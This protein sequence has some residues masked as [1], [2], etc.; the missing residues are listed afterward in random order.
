MGKFSL[1]GCETH[2]IEKAGASAIKDHL[3]GPAYEL[4][5]CR[6]QGILHWRCDWLL[7]VRYYQH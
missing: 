1:A 2:H 4:L 3:E 7:A 6:S 5:I